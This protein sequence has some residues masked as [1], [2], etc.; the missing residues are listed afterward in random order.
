MRANGIYRS[1]GEEKQD[2][3]QAWEKMSACAGV[4]QASHAGDM[5]G[6]LLY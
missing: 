2:G 1:Q 4:R 3:E 6:F 5:V